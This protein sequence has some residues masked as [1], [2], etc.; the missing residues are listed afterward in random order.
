MKRHRPHDV[1]IAFAANPRGDG[2]AYVTIEGEEAPLRIG[3]RIERFPALRGRE[4]GYG[5]LTAAADA[6]HARGLENVRLRVGDEPI[7]EDLAERR[8]LPAALTLPYVR[9]RCALNRFRRAEVVAG[10]IDEGLCAR[11]RAEVELAIAA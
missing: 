5:A 3:F 10:R 1:A 8:E 2:V 9:L 4:I 7:V 11:A 6:V